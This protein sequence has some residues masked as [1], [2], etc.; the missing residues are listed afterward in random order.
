MPNRVPD[1][2]RSELHSAANDIES[3]E[4]TELRLKRV[5]ERLIKQLSAEI[6]TR[7]FLRESFSLFLQTA[8]SMPVSVKSPSLLS[9]P[10]LSH[11]HMHP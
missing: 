6:R 9:L 7:E 5:H 8:T 2:A 3:T 11:A 1:G 4:V 10:S